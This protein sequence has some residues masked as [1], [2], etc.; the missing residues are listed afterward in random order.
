MTPLAKLREKTLGIGFGKLSLVRFV[1]VNVPE[2]REGRAAERGLA[3]L[4][5]TGHGDKGVLLEQLNQA[6]CNLALDHGI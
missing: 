3:G 4:P 2:M 5:W 1:E 6:G